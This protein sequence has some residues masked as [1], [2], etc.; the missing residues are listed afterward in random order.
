VSDE[1]DSKLRPMVKP[2]EALVRRASAAP[3]PPMKLANSLEEAAPRTFVH[4]DGK[5]QVRSPARYR[6][7]QAASYG[8]AAA[9]VGGVTVIYGGLLGLPGIGIG[10]A[11][12][13]YFGWHLKRGRMLHKATVLLVHDQLDEAEALLRKV[14]SSWRCPKHV[15]ALAEQNLGAVYNRRGNFEEALAHQRAAMAIYARTSGRSPMGRVVEY[16]EIITLVNLGRVG[17]A[18]Q[19]LDQ[20]HGQV[21]KGD[22]LRLQHWGAELYVCLAEGE[23]RIDGEQLHQCAIQA[24]K[25]TGAAALLGLTAWAHW[26]L[27]DSDQAW[28]LLREAYD[29][30][31]GVRLERSM[32]LLWKWMEEH[33][34]A[35]GVDKSEHQE[36]GIDDDPLAGF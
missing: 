13:A 27:N 36:P 1:A 21:P 16:A 3:A 18:R 8:A 9:L 35:A 20:K 10:A 23:H 15:R 34:E 25:I 26:K 28:H 5:G 29:R 31:H 2:D 7:L 6:A 32:P 19:R 14:L 24:L 11:F 22:Y 12:A 33:A 17:E 4:V 30:R